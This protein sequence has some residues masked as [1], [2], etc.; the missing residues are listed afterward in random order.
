MIDIESAMDLI[1]YGLQ[2]TGVNVIPKLDSFRVL[3]LFKIYERFGLKYNIGKPRISEKIHEVMISSEEVPR[4]TYNEQ[5]GIYY[6]HYKNVYNELP[7]N[8][9]SSK[10]SVVD[11]EQL[12][13]ILEK[14]NYFK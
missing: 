4:T 14:Y 1:E 9:Y 8:E 11:I 3:D 2:E 13:L 12:D 10:N 7:M 6:M 5:K